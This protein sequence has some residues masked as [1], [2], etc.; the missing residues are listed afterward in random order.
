[1]GW[2][3][4]FVGEKKPF[5]FLCQEILYMTFQKKNS[6]QTQK[7]KLKL[8]QDSMKTELWNAHQPAQV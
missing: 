6:T 1:M 7:T 4:H 5:S 3:G 8:K 2:L